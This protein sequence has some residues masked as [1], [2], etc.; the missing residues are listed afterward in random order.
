[1]AVL[2][3]GIT[4]RHSMGGKRPFQNRESDVPRIQKHSS[5]T[6]QGEGREGQRREG[7]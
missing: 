2:D 7:I 5:A 4:V 6:D 1:M 3:I